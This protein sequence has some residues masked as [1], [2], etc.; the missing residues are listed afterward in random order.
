MHQQCEIWHVFALVEGHGVETSGKET[1]AL[2]EG[3]H[4]VEKGA[5]KRQSP[6]IALS[7]LT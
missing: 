4:Q 2:I 3:G 1:Q 6:V 7:K 5:Q